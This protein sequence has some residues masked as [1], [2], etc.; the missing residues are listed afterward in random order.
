MNR[1]PE[2]FLPLDHL[3]AVRQLIR[4]ALAEDIGS[5]D[6]TSSAFIPESSRSLA[7]LIARERGIIA[8]LPLIDLFFSELD[9]NI[10]IKH[11]LADGS[12][13]REGEQI[14]RLSGSTRSLL[15]GERTILNFLQHLS[16]IATLTHAYV[17]ATKGTKTKILD[18]RKTTP[19]WRTLEKYA[20][21]LGGGTNHRFGL[22]DRIMLKDNHHTFIRNSASIAIV[23]AIAIC[24]RKYP[25]LPLEVEVDSLDTFRQILPSAP[26]Y[27]L[28]DNLSTAT[29]AA[30]VDIRNASSFK[31]TRLEAS[32]G[33]TLE[34]IPSL[35]RT[36][37]EFISVGALTHSVKAVDIAMEFR[38]S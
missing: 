26:D 23:D 4:M 17:Q 34:R 35:S 38:L 29:V 28:L 30:A 15:S 24:R 10:R 33:I 36:G 20:V 12:H 37:V 21:R 3:H 13:C 32:G 9:P 2:D 27:I 8:G 19:G 11:V 25:E 31:T 5:G 7:G 14:S 18:T 22:Y 16:G 6:A 1:T